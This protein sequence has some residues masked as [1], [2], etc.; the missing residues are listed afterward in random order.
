ML[1]TP[2][3]TSAA[4]LSR[5]TTKGP[6]AKLEELLLLELLV[7]PLAGSFVRLAAVIGS[8]LLPSTELFRSTAKLA[9]GKNRPSLKNAQR[10]RCLA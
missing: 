10:P 4:G 9:A 5:A 6:C 1:V 3:L 2:P 7:L 8:T